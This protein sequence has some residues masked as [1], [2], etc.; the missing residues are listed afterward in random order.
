ML[1]MPSDVSYLASPQALEDLRAINARFIQN[2]ITN[3]VAGHDALL[4]PDFITIQSN[5]SKLD[6]AAYLAQWATGFA[7][8]VIP[9]WDTRDEHITLVDNVAL[10]RSTNKFVVIEDGVGCERMAVYTDT[11]AYRNGAWTCLQAQ[12]TPVQ[13][14][15]HPSDDTIVSVYLHGVKQS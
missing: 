2:F 11:Y 8:D 4:H 6:R 9:Y 14:P 13:A 12:I 7:P 1:V 3:D 10:V 5:G 15:Y